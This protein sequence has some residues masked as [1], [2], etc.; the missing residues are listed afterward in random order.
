MQSTIVKTKLT[1]WVRSDS[2]RFGK[3]WAKEHKESISQLVSDY[4]LRLKKVGETRSEV[5]PIVSRM[6]GVIKGKT[7][8]RKD[9]RKHLED[10]YLNA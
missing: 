8:D 2:I 1:L 7:I 6:R 3:R 4:L 10:K 5:T 9:Y